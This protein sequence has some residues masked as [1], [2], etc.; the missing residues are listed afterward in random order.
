VAP[1]TYDEW[2]ADGK[3]WK[4]AQPIADLSTRLSGYGYTVY[5]IGNDA[6]LHA[7]PPEDHTPYSHTGW[8]ITSPY[9]YV[10]AM[11]IMPPTDS[12]LPTL[13]QLGAQLFADKQAGATVW[14][15]YMNW[16]PQGV[17]TG[18]CYHDEWQ[19]THTREN[20]TDR[21]H[22][23]ISIR[24]DYTTSTAAAGY[25]PVAR[26]RTGDDDMALTPAQ[27]AWLYNASSVE[28]SAW[29]GSA[30]APVRD[31]AG[32]T[33]TM[34]L[35][36]VQTINAIAADVAALKTQLATK[37]MVDEQE[38]ARQVLAALTPAAVADAVV[39][40]LPSDLAVQV[41]TE[42]SQRLNG[43]GSAAG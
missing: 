28:G 36:L 17:N 12:T 43:A 6:H 25:D 41:V 3:P 11:D 14:I 16:E 5:T 1:D 13:A 23:H 32:K 30:T 40:A 19:P 24:S 7:N 31:S 38:V 4:P 34:Q 35:G 20:S 33:G 39:A 26:I 27:D 2:V 10:H 42:L 22:I 18:P 29:Q 8:P 21:G 9:P 15:K 37:D